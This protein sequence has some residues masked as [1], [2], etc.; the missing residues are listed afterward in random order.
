MSAPSWGVLTII[1]APLPEQVVQLF[2]VVRVRDG[3]QDIAP[4]PAYK[5]FDQ[6]FLVALAWIA[7]L[8]SEGVVCF[9]E[10]EPAAGCRGH[11][12]QTAMAKPGAEEVNFDRFPGQEDETTACPQSARM[13]SPGSQASGMKTSFPSGRSSRT[14]RATAS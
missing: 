3:G 10:L 5:P 11:K 9:E 1:L 14:K 4:H 6:A 2:P 13:A 8:T 7:E 12:R